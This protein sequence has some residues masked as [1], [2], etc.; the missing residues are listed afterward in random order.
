MITQAEKVMTAYLA[1]KAASL[2]TIAQNLIRVSSSM[3]P[4]LLIIKSSIVE[5]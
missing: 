4:S 1:T 5:E 2:A 3:K